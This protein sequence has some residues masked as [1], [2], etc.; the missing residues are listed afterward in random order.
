MPALLVEARRLVAA[1]VEALPAG[2]VIL[3]AGQRC[4]ANDPVACTAGTQLAQ[5]CAWRTRGAH[6]PVCKPA[7]YNTMHINYTTRGTR[8]ET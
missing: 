4:C 6:V 3:P 1:E 8:H 2:R 7:S 5:P